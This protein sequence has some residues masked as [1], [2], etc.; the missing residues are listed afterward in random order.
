MS[1]PATVGENVRAIFSHSDTALVLALYCVG[2][3]R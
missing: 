2:T 3:C 1:D